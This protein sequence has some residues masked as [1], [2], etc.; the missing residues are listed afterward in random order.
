MDQ[1]W[2]F[3][4]LR[5]RDGSIYSGVTTGLDQRIEQHNRG[6]GA[7][8]TRGR[9]PVTLVY[10]EK[11]ADVSAAKKRESQV[12]TW[13]KARK[14]RLIMGENEPTRSTS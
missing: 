12:K 3:Y 6:T 11:H 8:Y 10:F 2:F 9:G 4:I 1:E 7:K 13:P 5:C 14:E